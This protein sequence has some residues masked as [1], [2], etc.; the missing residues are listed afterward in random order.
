MRR[1]HHYLPVPVFLREPT[2]GPLHVTFSMSNPQQ[3]PY[4]RANHRMTERVRLRGKFNEPVTA[5]GFQNLELTDRRRSFSRFAVGNEVVFPEESPCSLV[6]RVD[7]DLFRNPQNIS[8]P[9]RVKSRR[10]IADPVRVGT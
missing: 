2:R 4:K 5:M 7:V 6:H 10:V 1:G 8:P 9:Q 3:R